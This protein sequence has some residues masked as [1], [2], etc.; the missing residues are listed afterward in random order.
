MSFNMRNPRRVAVLLPY[1]MMAFS[2]VL[3]SCAKIPKAKDDAVIDDDAQNN[4]FFDVVYTAQSARQTGTNN[5]IK[6]SGDHRI[7]FVQSDKGAGTFIFA[8]NN[9]LEPQFCVYGS[10]CDCSGTVEGTFASPS[11]T[12][13]PSNSS[14][15]YSPFDPY[16][17]PSGGTDGTATTPDNP[18]TQKVYNFAFNLTIGPTQLL[19]TCRPQTDRTINIVRF[20]SGELIFRDDFREIY[21]TPTLK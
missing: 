7:K 20:L 8:F 16:A 4:A 12:S 21:F 2:L 15:P 11:S 19:P 10:T 3:G 14:P 5:W 18:N 1:L 9:Y 17:P 13:S 6:V